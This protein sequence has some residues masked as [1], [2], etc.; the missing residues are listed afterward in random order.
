MGDQKHIQCEE[1]P[2]LTYSLSTAIPFV[3]KPSVNRAHLHTQYV[4][5]VS[6]DRK[7]DVS[8]NVHRRYSEFQKFRQSI[9]EAGNRGM[10][11]VTCQRMLTSS[12]FKEFPKKHIFCKGKQSVIEK[13]KICFYEFLNLVATY[14][15]ICRKVAHRG[16]CQIRTMM[17][18][19]LM[20][21]QMRYTFVNIQMNQHTEEDAGKGKLFARQ[22]PKDKTLRITSTR[23]WPDSLRQANQT[24]PPLPESKQVPKT[25][26]ERAVLSEKLIS[27]ASISRK[28]DSQIGSQAIRLKT[29]PLTSESTETD[30]LS[31]STVKVAIHNSVQQNEVAQSNVSLALPSPQKRRT[32]QSY[33]HESPT[34]SLLSYSPLLREEP[35]SCRRQ[36]PHR[37]PKAKCSTDKEDT[38][39]AS[40]RK[41]A[42]AR[43]FTPMSTIYE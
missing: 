31:E 19:F 1:S 35:G 37:P 26:E 36:R 11:C 21:H 18:L 34:S 17:D 25:S 29:Q 24:L 30:L 15:S 13:R 40:R 8:W 38:Q 9:V 27:I 4:I 28:R 22:M 23:N 32:V 42:V 5:Q 12:S 33:S 20:A 39:V 6:D 7:C 41:Y 3:A 16:Q 14:A 10:L 2:S 43:T